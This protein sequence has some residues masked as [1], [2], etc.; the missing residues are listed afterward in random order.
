MFKNMKVG[1]KIVSGFSAITILGILVGI[2]GYMII[3]KVNHQVEIAETAYLIKQNCLDT[4]NQ[5]K[6]YIIDK[7][8]KVFKAWEDAVQSIKEI[9]AKGEKVTDDADIHG[10]LKDGIKELVRYEGFG[11]EF[12][13]LILAG[14]ELG[15]VPANLD[16]AARGVIENADMILDKAQKA[17]VSAQ[18]SGKMMI[19]I[20]LGICVLAAIGL[21][22]FI[23][24]GITR[25]V[26]RVVEGLSEGAEEVASAA[27]Q[28]S[29]S[30]QSLAEGASE[31]AASIEETSASLEEISSM[32]KQNAENAGQ[33]NN[34]ME[35]ANQAVGEAND[36]MGELTTSMED[37]SKASEETSKIIKTID[38]IAFQTNLLALN[39]A[40]EAA[41]AGEAGAGF[42]VVAEEVRNLAMRSADAA[43]NTAELIEGTVKKVNDGSELVNKTNET[44][45]KVAESASKVG[46][47]VGEIAAASNEQA[48]GIEQVNT[49]VSEMD[50]VTQTNSANSE[51]TAAASEEMNA[52]AEQ[53][54]GFVDNLAALVGGNANGQGNGQVS[55]SHPKSKTHMLPMAAKNKAGTG[56]MT[57][58]HKKEVKPNQV[59]PLDDG[60]F[61]DF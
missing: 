45:S 19:L 10:W 37:I 23:A 48:Q 6:S 36:A 33:A 40:V 47:L 12:H 42:A 25:P 20:I 34:L 17:M 56:K 31:Q 59:I 29:S 32:T 53:M 30:S 9:A 54:K 21:A 44:F 18:N 16:K 41:R 46:E 35:E 8:E 28:I 22:Y 49:A 13:R 27:G 50:K 43:K 2:A 15:Q 14:K 5:E 52:Q 38:E 55:V 57:V 11:H 58:L 4:R 60:D 1:T 39:A 26:K 24:T 7:D 3:N 51:E 61:Q